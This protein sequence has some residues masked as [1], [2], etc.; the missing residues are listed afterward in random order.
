MPASRLALGHRR[1]H[2][3]DEM[4]DD[5]NGPTGSTFFATRSV[6]VR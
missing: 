2:G 5:R 4:L 3:D 1:R 6:F